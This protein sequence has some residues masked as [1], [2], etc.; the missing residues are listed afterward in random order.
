M[1]ALGGGWLPGP[2]TSTSTRSPRQGLKSECRLPPHISIDSYG[3]L[4]R[5]TQHPTV[6]PTSPSGCEL[7][8]HI[9]AA[10]VVVRSTNQEEG[11]GR[12]HSAAVSL[13]ETASHT[14]A[15]EAEALVRREQVEEILS[16]IPSYYSSNIASPTITQTTCQQ[17]TQ[18]TS[19]PADYAQVDPSTTTLS[20]HAPHASLHE[21]SAACDGHMRPSTARWDFGYW[22]A[23]KAA[24]LSVVTAPTIPALRSRAQLPRPMASRSPPR[25]QKRPPPKFGVCGPE[26]VVREFIGAPRYVAHSRPP[27]ALAPPP[28]PRPGLVLNVA[29]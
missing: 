4:M 18:T 11:Q 20:E 17:I 8:T 7:R 26:V 15:P 24:K 1:P 23:A 16:T 19:P 13:Y 3:L 29:H 9:R 5:S 2:R 25:A 27:L 6:V 14:M 22:P 12:Q 28:S 10:P 21:P